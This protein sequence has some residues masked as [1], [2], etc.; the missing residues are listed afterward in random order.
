[1]TTT[2]P[3]NFITQHSV[4]ITVLMVLMFIACC[5]YTVWV[6][7]LDIRETRADALCLSCSGT[8]DDAGNEWCWWC[9][10]TGLR[11]GGKVR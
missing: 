9:S 7:V 1:M 10:G 11:H 8:G 4:I 5:A 3:D 6:M 2:P